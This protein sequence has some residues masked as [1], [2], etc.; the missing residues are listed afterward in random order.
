MTLTEVVIKPTTQKAFARTTKRLKRKISFKP[1]AIYSIVSKAMISAVF[2]GIRAG[3]TSDDALFE[4]VYELLGDFSQC[5][6][7]VSTDGKDPL[8]LPDKVF[9]VL[10]EK[11]ITYAR[12][13]Y[14]AR[15]FSEIQSRRAK[16]KRK[17]TVKHL[18]KVVNLSIA[19]SAKVLGCSTATVSRLRAQAKVT[20]FNVFLKAVSSKNSKF[21]QVNGSKVSLKETVREIFGFLI[22]MIEDFT[23]KSDG[24]VPKYQKI[25]NTV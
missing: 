13:I 10:V 23:P 18:F 1:K 25:F 17:Y 9:D 4:Y 22:E 21:S 20:S 16:A 8:S 2:S 7:E 19:E 6:Y 11:Q 14:D 12:E 5:S 15:Q 3:Y 24:K